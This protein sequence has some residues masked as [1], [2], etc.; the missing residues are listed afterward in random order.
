[1]ET[2]DGDVEWGH[3]GG[4]YWLG[5]PDVDTRQKPQMVIL[6]VSYGWGQV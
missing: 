4:S 3:W 5:M 6:G 2:L 1:M